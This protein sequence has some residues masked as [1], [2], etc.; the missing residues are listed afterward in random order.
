MTSTDDGP[1]VLLLS[2]DPLPAEQAG[3]VAAS[4]GLRCAV[5][6]DPDDAVAPVAGLVVVGAD[7]LARCPPGPQ[8]LV[9]AADGEVVP[10]AA[11]GPTTHRL[12]SGRDALARYL[13][14]G[15]ARRGS[16]TVVG[17]LG[18]VG[19]A[20]ASTLALALAAAGRGWLLDLDP[21]RSCT[22][23]ATGAEHAEGARWPDLQHLAGRLPRG[24][25][26]ERLPAADGVPLVGW[27][28]LDGAGPGGGPGTAAVEAVVAAGRAG[29]PVVVLDLP[30]AAAAT[31]GPVW[32]LV[33]AAVLVVPDEVPAAVTGRRIVAALRAVVGTVHVVVRERRAGGPG[34][35]VVAEVL[36]VPS[37]SRWRRQPA[38]GR[39]ADDGELVAAVRRGPT[40]AVA[41]ELIDVLGVR[42]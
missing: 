37:A 31:A 16:G 27:S 21:V 4:V 6:T 36:G 33:D 23:A 20:G 17:V 32:R 7:L 29:A 3:L 15:T 14:D 11:S 19:G 12:P 13:A 42:R 39:A 8:D 30:A 25:L 26:A 9:V 2:G 10:P 41:A 22:E 35:R 28:A 18:A 24:L 34:A 1:G 5:S 38:L 40:S